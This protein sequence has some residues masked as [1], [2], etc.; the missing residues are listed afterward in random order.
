[1]RAVTEKVR[2]HKVSG[3]ADGACMKCGT[4]KRGVVMFDD[5]SIGLE[6]VDCGNLEKDIDAEFVEDKD[7]RDALGDLLGS[8]N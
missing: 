5:L 2:I 7:D 1:M 3:L 8:M 4:G 6:C